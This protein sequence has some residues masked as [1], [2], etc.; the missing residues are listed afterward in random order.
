MKESKIIDFFV[1]IQDNLN[2]IKFDGEYYKT[3]RAIFDKGMKVCPLCGKFMPLEKS[4]CRCGE[5]VFVF[6]ELPKEE[7]LKIES[8]V[9]Q[10]SSK[11]KSSNKKPVRKLY[12]IIGINKE[13]LKTEVL[14]E[15]LSSPATSYWLANEKKQFTNKYANIQKQ[16]YENI[17]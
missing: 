17:I 14:T 12:I 9:K 8:A 16:K 6:F 2:L 15:P 1:K 11:K 7:L 4:H 3:T 5:E 10:S 13:T